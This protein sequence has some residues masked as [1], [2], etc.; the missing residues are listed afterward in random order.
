MKTAKLIIGIIS[1]CLCLIVCFQSCTAGLVNTLEDNGEV[2]G[3]AGMIVGFTMLVAGI[4]SIAT[5]KG[6]KGGSIVAMIFYFIGG[7]LGIANVGTFADLKIWSILCLIFGAIHL[8][9]LFK[10]SKEV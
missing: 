3:S 6:G 5:R 1:I 9:G 7:L 2:S 4:I 8:L 10:K